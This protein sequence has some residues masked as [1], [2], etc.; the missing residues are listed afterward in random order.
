MQVENILRI[1]SVLG[2]EIQT[3][4]VNTNGKIIEYSSHSKD[5]SKI[6]SIYL[7]KVSEVKQSI[8]SVFVALDDH[9]NA[10]L[11]FSAIHQNYL[12]GKKKVNKGQHL[13]VQIVR[14]ASGTKLAKCTTILELHGLN[15]IF[16]P[17]KVGHHGISKKITGA[18]KQS[19]KEF[20]KTIDG[21]IIV[22]TASMFSTIEDLQKEYDYLRNIWEK[23]KR[24]GG[25]NKNIGLLY[26]DDYVLN[27]FRQYSCH[28]IKTVLI[29]DIDLYKKAA[30][31][32]SKKLLA[33]PDDIQ[34]INGDVF[35][36]IQNQIDDFY[37]KQLILPS[38]GSI[39][40]EQTQALISIDVNSKRSSGANTEET[41]FK[42]NL[43][44]AEVIC[45][46][47]MLR[48]LGGIIAIDF[49][50]MEIAAHNEELNKKIK[51]AM[52]DD[53]SI[54]KIIE[55]NAFGIVH[56]SRQRRGR[57][58]MEKAFDLC[59]HCNGDGMRLSNHNIV[60]S[61]LS[62][63]QFLD[64]MTVYTTSVIMLIIINTYFNFIS[65]KYITWELVQDDNANVHSVKIIKSSE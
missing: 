48:N 6:G 36:E 11:P 31:Y 58:V 19:I 63:I 42:T 8:E 2:Q 3:V 64:Y 22:R 14:D 26:E 37:K 54:V 47:I 62:K 5:K 23:I 52:K 21:S 60:I 10:F 17:N 35:A 30:Q 13:I 40:F 49:I 50:D 44:A 57:N 7:A 46:Q 24:K 39:I 59:L 20:L 56:I 38:G 1:Q 43:E 65:K 27:I 34:F 61:L 55:I 33:F 16:F 12:S 28:S 9:T 51:F 32:A 41:A 4:V 45:E 25:Q 53:K 18:I 15:C 29:N